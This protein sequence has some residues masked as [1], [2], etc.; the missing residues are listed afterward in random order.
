MHSWSR[1]TLNLQIRERLHVR[2]GAAVTNFERRLAQ[3]Q[4]GLATQ[5]LKDPY[6]FDFLGLGAEAHERDIENALMRHITRFL[7]ELGFVHTPGYRPLSTDES[8]LAL[9]SSFIRCCFAFAKLEP[10]PAMAASRIPIQ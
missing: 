4:A 1:E 9:T 6:Y 3:R 7:L 5:I 2:K 8:A 10:R